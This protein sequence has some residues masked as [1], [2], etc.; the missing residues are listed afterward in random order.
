MIGGRRT[1][2]LLVAM[3]SFAGVAGLAGCGSGDAPASP[4]AE[5]LPTAPS[6][7]EFEAGLIDGTPI[8]TAALADDVNVFWFW[9]PT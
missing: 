3:M 2:A 4:S 1:A 5:S 7:L 6:A 8:D 9:A